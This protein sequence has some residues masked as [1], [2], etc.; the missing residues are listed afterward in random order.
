MDFGIAKILD[1]NNQQLTQSGTFGTLDYIAPEQI[2][3]AREVDGR[4]DLYALG[5]M[6]YQMLTGELPYK[7]SNAGQ[8][9]FGHLQQPAPDPRLLVPDLPSHVSAAIRKALE[10]NPDDRFATSGAFAAELVKVVAQT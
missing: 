5:V 7:G 6:V 2:T 10:K 8:V 3:T 4:A 1:T 9:L